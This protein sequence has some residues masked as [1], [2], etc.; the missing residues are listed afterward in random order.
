M[1]RSATSDVARRNPNKKKLTRRI[2][3][4]EWNK[5]KTTIARPPALVVFEILCYLSFCFFEKTK[6]HLKQKRTFSANRKFFFM[7]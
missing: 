7:P 4:D 3:Q 2:K 6:I 1:L 5:T